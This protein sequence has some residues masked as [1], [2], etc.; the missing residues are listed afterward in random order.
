MWKNFKLNKFLLLI[1]LTSLMF[2]FNS[3][4]NDDEKM[5]TIMVSV[6]NTLSYPVNR[7]RKGVY[8]VV[9]TDGSFTDTKKLLVK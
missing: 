3:P 6:K 4:K 7:L 2:C 5:Q 1:P 9:A 8:I